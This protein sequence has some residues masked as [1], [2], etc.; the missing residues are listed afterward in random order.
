MIKQ[1]FT[2]AVALGAV[3]L[4][5]GAW[6]YEGHHMVNELALASLPKDFGIDLT[7]A[8]KGRVAFLAGEPDRWR[9]VPDLPLKHFNG[10]DHY[11]DV[12]DLT[13]CG[14]TLETLPIMRYDFVAILAN[15]RTAHPE[16][17]PVIDPAKDADHTRELD[18][19]LPWAITEN[20]EKLKSDF[21][22]LKAFQQ[23]GGTPEEIANAKADCIYVMGVMGHYVGDAAQPLHTTKHFN[24]WAG[25]NPNGYTVKPTFHSLIDGGY[26]KKTGGLHFDAL[27]GKIHPAEKIANAD[28]PEGMFRDAAAYIAAQ[29]KFVAPLYQMEKDGQLTGEGEKGM[30]GRPFLEGQI[31]KA[32]QMLGNIWLTAWLDA[33]ADTYLQ[34]QLEQRAAAGSQSQ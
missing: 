8:L 32:G 24:G 27:V 31:V 13:L 30:E 19:F 1:C 34:R 6:D 22:S 15:A 9:N 16:K 29:N 26:F 3:T 25:E 14:L 2:M 28:E 33:P 18:G 5:I 7:P 4:N 21:S 23:Y 12:E 11:L 10:P 20:Y 17:F